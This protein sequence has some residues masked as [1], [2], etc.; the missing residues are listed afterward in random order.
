MPSFWAAAS[1]PE[2]SRLACGDIHPFLVLLVVFDRRCVTQP[3]ALMRPFGE[4]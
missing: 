3:P 1:L 2:H 4:R